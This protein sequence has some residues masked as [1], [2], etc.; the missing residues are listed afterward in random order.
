MAEPTTRAEFIENCLR[1]LGK[2]VIQINVSTEQVDDR[3]D[4]ALSMYY[5]YHYDGA[6]R[7]FLKHQLTQT[8]IDNGYIT[9]PENII[10]ISNIFNLNASNSLSTGMF[11]ARYQFLLNNIAD[12]ASYNLTYY[13]MSMDHLALLEEVLVGQ[14]PIRYNRHIDKLYVDTDWSNMRPGQWLV[15]ECYSIIDP[16][17]YSDVWKD[18]WLQRY[19]SALIK[20]QWGNNLTKYEGLQLAGNVQ[21]NGTQILQEAKEEKEKLEEQLMNDYSLPVNGMIG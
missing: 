7:T 12:I 4:E 16:E 19:A 17:E 10:G 21:F 9:V 13:T 3:V 1:R 15:A 18:R 11:S 8:D 5:D 14:Q 20:L 2:P 6:E